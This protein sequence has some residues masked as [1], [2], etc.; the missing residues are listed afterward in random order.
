MELRYRVCYIYCEIYTTLSLSFSL[1]F[2]YETKQDYL[3]WLNASKVKTS[4]LYLEQERDLEAIR[5][6]FCLFFIH[7]YGPWNLDRDDFG[8]C[9]RLP[10]K[11]VSVRAQQSSAGI[12]LQWMNRCVGCDPGNCS[13]MEVI[14][15]F[16]FYYSHLYL[17]F[18]HLYGPWILDREDFGFCIRVPYKA[19]SV[20]SLTSRPGWMNRCLAVILVTAAW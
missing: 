16:I 10:H 20:R 12:T 6:N 19:V 13:L 7:L 1:C 2:D 18:T 14:L 11:A 5:H 8:F 15:F 3:A 4:F 17:L 9:I